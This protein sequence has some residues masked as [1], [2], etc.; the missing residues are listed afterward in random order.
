MIA[1]ATRQIGNI[2]FFSCYFHAVEWILQTH[3][4]A[5]FIIIIFL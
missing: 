5:L 1:F 4:L 3:K 2:Q